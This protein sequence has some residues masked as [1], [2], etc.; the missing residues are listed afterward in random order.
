MQRAALPASAS[1]RAGLS[2]A[3]S[4]DST[5]DVHPVPDYHMKDQ[6][7]KVLFFFIK[8]CS[9]ILSDVDRKF[10]VRMLNRESGSIPLR[11]QNQIRRSV[12]RCLY[13]GTP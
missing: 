3:E 7:R 8:N 1:V 5:F 9:S 13:I 10:A 4:G 12:R 2:L 6:H 11:G